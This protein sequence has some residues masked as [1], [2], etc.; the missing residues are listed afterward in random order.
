LATWTKK[1]RGEAQK[2][3]KNMIVSVTLLV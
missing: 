2:F 1:T 3:F